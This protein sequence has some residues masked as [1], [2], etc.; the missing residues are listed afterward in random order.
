MGLAMTSRRACQKEF[1]GIGSCTC[2]I[3]KLVAKVIAELLSHA[4]NHATCQILRASTSTCHMSDAY[5]FKLPYHRHAIMITSC[6]ET[7][8]TKPEIF[9]IN[10]TILN[11][12]ISPIFLH[13]HL[14]PRNRFFVGIGCDT[15]E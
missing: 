6:H 14:A 8:S 5:H 2:A 9:S 10:R 3:L 1:Y 7:Q 12:E 15:Q 13:C 11:F 4:Q